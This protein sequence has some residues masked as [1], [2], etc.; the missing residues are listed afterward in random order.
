MIRENFVW[1]KYH[2]RIVDLRNEIN[3]RIEALRWTSLP[4]PFTI[5]PCL[6]CKIHHFLVAFMLTFKQSILIINITKKCKPTK[7]SYFANLC[8]HSILT[9]RGVYHQNHL[10]IDRTATSTNVECKQSDVWNLSFA[11]TLWNRVS[12]LFTI[13]QVFLVPWIPYGSHFQE[14]QSITYLSILP[15]LYSKVLNWP[16]GSKGYMIA[17]YRLQIEFLIWMPCSIIIAKKKTAKGCVWSRLWFTLIN[18]LKLI[19]K[20]SMVFEENY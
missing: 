5:S 20:R 1:Y 8:F 11:I 2:N 10:M 7:S 9:L 13:P 15:A 18:N 12:N 19:L 6:N 3:K 16:V 17:P 14:T 4:V